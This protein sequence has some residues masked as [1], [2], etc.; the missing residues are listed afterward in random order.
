MW[1]VIYALSVLLGLAGGLG[2]VLFRVM[3]RV[4]H[5]FFFGPLLGLLSLEV[6]GYNLGIILLPAI[7]GLYIRWKALRVT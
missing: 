2:A 4:V 7:G 6:G 5:D 3:I 1:L